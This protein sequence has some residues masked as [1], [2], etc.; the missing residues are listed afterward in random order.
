VHDSKLS[1]SKLLHD[2][3]GVRVNLPAGQ[4][5]RVEEQSAATRAG[6][7]ATQEDGNM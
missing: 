3:K 4:E 2:L 1:L 5:E 6:R 7:Q